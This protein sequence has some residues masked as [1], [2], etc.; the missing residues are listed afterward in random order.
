MT[1]H[2]FQGFGPVY[3][4]TTHVACRHKCVGEQSR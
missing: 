3:F 1:L 2:R 4:N